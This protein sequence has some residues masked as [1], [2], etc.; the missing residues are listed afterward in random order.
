MRR[1][2]QIL[3]AAIALAVSLVMPSDVYAEG[4]ENGNF[5]DGLTG[6]T[7]EGTGVT[8]ENGTDADG[9]DQ[10]AK[11]GPGDG[12]AGLN[13]IQLS[14]SF[15]CAE[16]PEEAGACHITFSYQWNPKAGDNERMKVWLNGKVKLDLGP[17]DAQDG[18]LEETVIGEDCGLQRIDIQIYD[19][20]ELKID[21]EALV[22]SFVCDCVGEDEEEDFSIGGTTELL[23]GDPA[24]RA[25]GSAS[26]GDST[27]PIAAATGGLLVALA[28]A[29][30]FVRRRLV[31]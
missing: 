17:E 28:G 19:P 24:A 22:D 1:S 26:T 13:S 25:E 18:W 3:A 20:D 4:I 16:D 31:R 8:A 7:S 10:F 11:I 14:Q 6:W 2:V 27:L 5:G 9:N 23:V 12:L 30:L 21:S 15:E 29:G